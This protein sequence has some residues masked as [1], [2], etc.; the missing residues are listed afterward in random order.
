MWV[1]YMLSVSVN[2]TF[3]LQYLYGGG[4]S[5]RGGASVHILPRQHERT[6]PAQGQA[7]E[8]V[9]GLGLAAEVGRHP[10]VHV[11]RL[12]VGEARQSDGNEIR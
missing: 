11:Q 7:V 12:S 1:R 3:Q 10:R 6:G 2:T 8:L 5:W 4:Y 9:Q